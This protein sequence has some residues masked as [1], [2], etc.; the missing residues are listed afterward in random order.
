[1]KLWR[2]VLLTL[3][4][5][6]V[7]GAVIIMPVL[8]DEPFGVITS[9]DVANKKVGFLSKRGERFEFEIK[10]KTEI[11]NGRGEKIDLEAVAKAVS[12][13]NSA[14]TLYDVQ[15]MP[16]LKDASGISTAG[17]NLVIVAAV[18][19]VLHFRVFDDNGTVVV[20]ID[21]KRLMEQARQIDDLRKELE[22]LWPPHELTRSD[23]RRVLTTLT[24]IVG[25]IPGIKGAFARVTH[26]NKVVS[27]IS[28]GI[29]EVKQDKKKQK[30]KEKEKSKQE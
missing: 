17:K 23:K 2:D 5:V 28:V 1:M 25:H 18:N 9:V 3:T 22:S 6:L 30:P 8:A 13:A 7:A 15:L 11:V 21:E 27:K 26:E 29:A 10:D 14:G 24:S 19:N 4:A 16:A 12:K 20:D